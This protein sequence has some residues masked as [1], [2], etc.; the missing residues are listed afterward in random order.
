M[1]VAFEARQLS[2]IAEAMVYPSYVFLTVWS[3]TGVRWASY[4]FFLAL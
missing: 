1:E 2:E 3:I 4:K